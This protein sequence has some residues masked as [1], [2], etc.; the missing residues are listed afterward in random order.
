[1]AKQIEDGGPAFPVPT[2]R[3][4]SGKAVVLAEHEGLSIRDYFAAAALTG[5]LANR[6]FLL[7]IEDGDVMQSALAA[8]NSYVIA[9]AMLAAMEAAREVMAELQETPPTGAQP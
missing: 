5:L 8:R 7:F 9:D 4:D 1:M 6:E 2:F 3:D